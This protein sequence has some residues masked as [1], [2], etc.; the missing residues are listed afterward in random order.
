MTALFAWLITWLS[1]SLSSFVSSSFPS[2]SCRVKTCSV[3]PVQLTWT[4]SNASDNSF[5][6][7]VSPSTCDVTANSTCCALF[8]LLVNKFVISVAPACIRNVS[9]VTDSKLVVF[10]TSVLK[11]LILYVGHGER[12]RQGR[13]RVPL[14]LHDGGR[15]SPHGPRLDFRDR[16]G[17]HDLHLDQVVGLWLHRG[18]LPRRAR[19]MR[20]FG[21]R[22]RA[23]P[24]LPDV[25]VPRHA[26]DEPSCAAASRDVATVVAVA[27]IHDVAHEAIPP[28]SQVTPTAS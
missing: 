15:A 2:G 7:Y 11:V 10:S 8:D 6:F 14:Q 3:A 5:C 1:L 4:T 22:C 20:L 26:R 23:S 25:R 28:T 13:R 9:K 18:L 16:P 27:H 21:V 19:C 12:H 24:L 17:P